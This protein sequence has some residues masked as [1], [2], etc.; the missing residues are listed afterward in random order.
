MKI[1]ALRLFNVKRFV[2]SDLWLI[3]DDG[4]QARTLSRWYRLGD[5]GTTAGNQNKPWRQ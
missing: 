5:P 1:S 4:Q 3:S 2:T